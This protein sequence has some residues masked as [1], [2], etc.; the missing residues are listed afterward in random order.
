MSNQPI[1]LSFNTPDFAALRVSVSGDVGTD[2]PRRSTRSGVSTLSGESTVFDTAVTSASPGTGG[3]ATSDTS[4]SGKLYQVKHVVDSSAL[5][6]CIIPSSDGNRVC[7]KLR[8]ECTAVSHVERVALEDDCLYVSPRKDVIL[9]GLS[10]SRQ[11]LSDS[12]FKRTLLKKQTI[13]VWSV[14]FDQVKDSAAWEQVDT[15]TSQITIEE[16]A[17][18]EEDL[19]TP[20]KVRLSSLIAHFKD[21]DATVDE[22]LS[23]PKFLHRLATLVEEGGTMPTDLEEIVKKLV[24]NWDKI[25]TN[26]D[27]LEMQES[28]NRSTLSSLQVATE[29]LIKTTEDKFNLIDTKAKIILNLIG[30][31]DAASTNGERSIWKAISLLQKECIDIREDY[32]FRCLDIDARYV[33]RWM[34][35]EKAGQVD[36]ESIQRNE[37]FLLQF[38]KV[39][40]GEMKK[41]FDMLQNL[42]E[43]APSSPYKAGGLGASQPSG[44]TSAQ[45]N[46]LEPV[47]MDLVRF[48][49]IRRIKDIG[50]RLTLLENDF[51]SQPPAGDA[52]LK[53]RTVDWAGGFG[54]LNSTMG[55]N[56][57]GFRERGNFNTSNTSVDDGMRRELELLK[58]HVL[59]L[60]KRIKGES[61]SSREFHINSFAEAVAFVDRT[62][63]DIAWIWDIFSVLVSMGS[64]RLD[65]K[66]LSDWRHSASKTRTTKRASQLEA[67]M[68]SGRPSVFFGET[69]DGRARPLKEGMAN[70]TS[71]EQWSGT[72]EPF[73]ETCTTELINFIDGIQG[74]LPELIDFSD[75]SEDSKNMRDGVNLAITLLVDIQNQ[76]TALT[77]F[78]QTA[79]ND[80]TVRGKFTSKTAWLLVGRYV[81]AIFTAM[82]TVRNPARGLDDPTTLKSRAT[83]FWSVLQCHRIMKE[84]IDEKFMG[85]PL[86]VKETS[87]FTLTD[88]VSEEDLAE[89]KDK[90]KKE[91]EAQKL[92]IAALEADKR[93]RDD[94]IKDLHQKYSTLLNQV[95]QLGTKL[96]KL[97]KK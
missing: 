63:L 29:S 37:E 53:R 61:Y 85:H 58:K 14:Y 64:K 16:A 43:K 2:H 49:P 84:F 80:L 95:N 72:H 30:S 39:F 52:G 50:E 45:L 60:Q 7:A 90:I 93:S 62:N 20:K 71:W 15:P 76:W 96:D 69:N 18:A 6:C 40:E 68:S 27:D 25:Q 78:I 23:K 57:D 32:D 33:T 55:D 31:D 77:G 28:I 24:E 91:L 81:A 59:E 38:K 36:R 11:W 51:N 1:E 86:I 83:L 97:G 56:I 66:Q 79:Y 92:K 35:L 46:Q 47:L 87:F 74:D 22:L 10:L 4:Y 19:K 26:F 94:T 9:R 21:D 89:H 73:K 12:E 5:C 42:L 48:D 75:G 67:S 65:A 3:G 17:R 8:E 88:R 34:N 70:C 13:G 54:D 44:R 82:I 41:I